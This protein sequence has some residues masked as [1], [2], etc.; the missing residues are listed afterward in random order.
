MPARHA[1]L[2]TAV[3]LV[4]GVNFVIIDVALGAFPPLLLVAV[5]FTLVAFPAV[6][7]FG[8]P[9]IGWRW[10]VAIGATI[11]AGQFAFLFVAMDRGMPAG[12]ASLVLQLQVF[13]TVLL[14]MVTLGE[15]PQR[16]QLVAAGI[17]FA[18]I[19]V[20]A[21]G[22]GADVPLLACALSVGASL[23][24]AVGNVCTRKAQAPRPVELLV[25][26]SLVPPL[27]LLGLSLGFEGAGA[28]G[29]AWAALDLGSIA[30]LAYLVLA[31]TAFGYGAWGYL[32]RHNPA[33]QV[34]PFTLL[35]P[36]VGIAA[37]WIALGEVP[38]AAELAGGVI[39]LAGLV[40]N[41][42]AG[43]RGRRPL[44]PTAPVAAAPSRAA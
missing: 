29:D 2:A 10:V 17:G 38:N 21:T 11:A 41:A 44:S 36:P 19:A 33:S 3:A 4:W 12:L 35:V 22:R 42:W 7:F 26:T 24:W 34:V 28:I 14:A 13:F 23:S 37:A 9:G 31:S 25:W 40:L 18:G 39:I 16:L 5:R 8:R 20:I 15:R 1:A 27:P 43:M 32:I 6:F 30:A